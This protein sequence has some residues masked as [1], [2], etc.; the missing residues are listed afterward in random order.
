MG[1][2][3]LEKV[4]DRSRINSKD[5]AKIIQESVCNARRFG[6]DRG[7]LLPG[8]VFR[9]RFFFTCRPRLSAHGVCLEVWEKASRFSCGL[10]CPNLTQMNTTLCRFCAHARPNLVTLSAHFCAGSPSQ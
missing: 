4:M 9:Q 5:Q 8:F 7:N 1:F 3:L 10:P 2:P 6:A